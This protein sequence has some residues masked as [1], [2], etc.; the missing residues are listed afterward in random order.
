MDFGF[1]GF[2]RAPEWRVRISRP[3]LLSRLCGGALDRGR[4]LPEQDR[5][6]LRGADAAHVG[7]HRLRLFVG[8]LAR[9]PGA[10]RFE[11]A[12]EV[13][14]LGYVLPLPFVGQDP[15]INRTVRHL[16]IAGDEIA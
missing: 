14:E 3:E 10:D 16:D 4:G 6:L 9:G 7:V 5:V 1:A 15:R 13:R 2:S 11:P 8:A 12:L